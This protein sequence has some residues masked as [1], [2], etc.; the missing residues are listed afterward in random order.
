MP[1]GSITTTM[2]ERR[3][4][5]RLLAWSSPAF[6]AGSFAYS[7]GLET[8]IASGMVNNAAQ[9]RDWIEANLKG[10][11][12]RNDAIFAAEAGRAHAD[13][14]RLGELAELCLALLPAR[15]RQEEMLLTGAAF[16][17]AARAWPDSVHDRLPAP[18]PYPVAF[19]AMAG[20][21]GIET[22]E[23]IAAFLTAYIQSQ[24]SV[25]VRL[26][27]IG[28]SG[29]LAIQAALEPLVT[30]LSAGLCDA[31]T[32]DLGSVAYAADIAAMKHE[33]LGTRIFRS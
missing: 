13:A 12:A 28:Q 23:T 17:E 14:R 19:G 10:G 7:G 5:Q 29:G 3:A 31:T 27:P 25:A 24:A 8:A 4:L 18:C 2:I 20:A 22:G 33:T 32:A 30:E 16:A 9:T 26:V 11:G 15:Q 1:T 6:P 21:A